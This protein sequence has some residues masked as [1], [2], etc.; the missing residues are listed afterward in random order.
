MRRLGPAM[1]AAMLLVSGCNDGGDPRSGSSASPTISST[2]SPSATEPAPEPASEPTGL[3]SELPQDV[4]PADGRLL[5]L[6]GVSI[7]IPRDWEASKGSAGE[8]FFAS[9]ADGTSSIDLHSVPAP[10]GQMSLRQQAVIWRKGGS[11]EL[12]PGILPA[13]ELNG[14]LVYHIA[15]PTSS[16]TY[17]EQFGTEHRGR[18]ISIRFKFDRSVPRAQ[19]EKPV[20]SVLATWQWRK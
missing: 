11:Y 13:T 10:G 16:T 4:R 7:R 8:L 2:A 6:P 5:K 14:V 9:D 17:L 3:P 12:Q 15:G 20:A 1:A 18:M 19:R